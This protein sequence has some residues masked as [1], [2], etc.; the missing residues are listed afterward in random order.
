M[1]ASAVIEMVVVGL[2]PYPPSDLDL[3][4][5]SPTFQVADK[6][7]NSHKISTS[8]CY[9][10]G[11]NSVKVEDED[12]IIV[13][14]TTE[15]FFAE[16]ED[17]EPIADQILRE[18]VAR[19]TRMGQRRVSK[20]SKRTKLSTTLYLSQ[21]YGGDQEFHSTP[22][23][24]RRFRAGSTPKKEAILRKCPYKHR[25]LIKADGLSLTSIASKSD[26]KGRRGSGRS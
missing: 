13:P 25:L 16:L 5:L 18:M 3:I 11:I 9:T 19:K 8:A 2:L 24:R 22:A 17:N 15:K 7:A 21:K 26:S 20:R 23:S 10:Q 1:D 6:T 12:P 14:F 4:K